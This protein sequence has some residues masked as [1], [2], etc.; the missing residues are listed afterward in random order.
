MR[1]NRHTNKPRWHPYPL[2]LPR[3]CRRRG[4]WFCM[5]ISM[6]S[7]CGLL[8]FAGKGYTAHFVY[9]LRDV[10]ILGYCVWSVWSLD[11]LAC[12]CCIYIFPWICFEIKYDWLIDWFSDLTWSVTM[13]LCFHSFYQLDATFGVRPEDFSRQTAARNHDQCPRL[14]RR[15]ASDIAKRNL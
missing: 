5:V 6:K 9:L 12:L 13:S 8:L 2:P 3:D 4:Q 1:K 10:S 7:S 14:T 15:C 11:F